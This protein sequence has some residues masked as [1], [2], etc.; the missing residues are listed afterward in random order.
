[1]KALSIKQ[2]WAWAI[3]CGHKTIE[4]RTWSTTYRGPLLIA[5]SKTPD[6]AMMDWLT[7]QCGPEILQQIGLASGMPWHRSRT[8]QVSLET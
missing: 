4:T 7:G 2:P 1:M 8:S 3:A 5:A 6:R